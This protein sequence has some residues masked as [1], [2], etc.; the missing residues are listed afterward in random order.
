MQSVNSARPFNDLYWQPTMANIS[1]TVLASRIT[2]NVLHEPRQSTQA[3]T[4]KRVSSP[5]HPRRPT[6]VARFQSRQS[7][8]R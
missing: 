4:A 7:A 6:R 3:S 2:P 1:C 5:N 8:I